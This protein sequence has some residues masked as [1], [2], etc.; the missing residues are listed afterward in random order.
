VGGWGVGVL[1][2]EDGGKTW[3]DRSA[4]LPNKEIWR[5]T[6]DPDIPRRLYAAPHLSALHVSDD[7]G[8]NWR[9]LTF[10]KAIVYDIVFIARSRAPLPK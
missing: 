7:L 8:H 6:A 9:P 10:E 4:G 5:V 1:V 3:G 2:S